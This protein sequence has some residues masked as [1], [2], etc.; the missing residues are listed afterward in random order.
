MRAPYTH[1]ARANI[2]PQGKGGPVL[3]R[4][5]K[6]FLLKSL[7]SLFPKAAFEVAEKITGSGFCAA[8]LTRRIAW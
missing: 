1:P 7:G 6:I 8:N 5:E 2:P 4:G 3:K